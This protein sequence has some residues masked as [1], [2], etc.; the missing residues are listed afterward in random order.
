MEMQVQ[1]EKTSNI[2]RKLT[3][4]VPAKTV[5]NRFENG[6]AEVAKTAKFKGF[7]PGHVPMSVVKQYYGDDVRHRVFHN[8]IDESFR[9]AVREQQLKT[10]GAPKIDTP[11][12]QTGE[13]AHDHTIQENQDLTFTATVEVLPEVEVKG[14]TGI[15]LTQG[16][17]EV[18]NEDIETTV[19]NLIDSQAELVPAA[20]GLAMADGS[21]SS[22]PAQMGDFADMNFSGGL[23]TETGIEEKA[24]MKG[25]RVIE[26]GS[27]SLIPGFEEQVVGMRKGET[28]T[29]RVR[30]PKDYGDE[31]FSDKEAEF[32][33][34]VN[35]LKE[36][37]LPEVNDEFAKKLGYESV[38]DMRVKAKE[39]LVRTR[40]EDVERKLRSDL[41]QALIEKNPFEVPQSLIEAQTRAL[42][43]DVAGNL[44]QQGFNQEMIQEVLMGELEN[45]KKRAENQVRAS[46]ILE[47]IAKAENIKVS[48][49]EMDEEI[50]KVAE[51]MRVEEAKLREYY[52]GRPEK[53][54]D[55]EF[56]VREER[57]M[58]LLLEKSKIKQEK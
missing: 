19:K 15:A 36:K 44:Q 56:R 40:G 32:T 22:R 54:A 52:M 3:I 42:A 55:L 47:A 43:Q 17:A 9:E 49:S 41:L 58:K 50:K 35:E 30:F 6:L 1:V 13:G 57:T 26:L 45:L 48:D 37:K 20:G 29:F 28:K 27:N 18:N 51:G 25:T 46:L 11:D 8:L 31:S 24:G 12:H 16:K 21:M 23:V 14:Y 10:V 33:V 53:K 38:A 4:R 7:R 39:H 5:A 2:V 34:T